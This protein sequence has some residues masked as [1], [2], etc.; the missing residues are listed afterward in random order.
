MNGKYDKRIDQYV[1]EGVELTAVQQGYL[2]A[3]VELL[4]KQDT[5]KTIDVAQ[6]MNK[7]TS[8][9]SSAMRTLNS[10]GI[11]ETNASGGITLCSPG[12]KKPGTKASASKAPAKATSAKLS[13]FN[14]RVSFE[15]P[16][17][18]EMI[19]NEN[20]D[21]TRSCQ[22]VT[23]KYRKDDGNDAYKFMATVSETEIQDPD[24]KPVK[25]EKPL[26]KM[27]RGDPERKFVKI[28]DDPA[29]EF[30]VKAIPLSFLSSQIKLYV[31]VL[32]V[33]TSAK[34]AVI[35]FQ[36][37]TWDEEHPEEHLAQFKQLEQVAKAIR[38]NGNPLKLKR[39]TIDSISKKL[40]PDYDDAASIG[41]I[42][43]NIK[44]DD[45]LVYTD[46]EEQQADLND[47]EEKCRKLNC[48][49]WA[50]QLSDC[51][52]KFIEEIDIPYGVTE[53]GMSAFEGCSMLRRVTIPDT[54]TR[55]E[56]SAFEDCSALEEIEIPDSVTEMQGAIF[57]NCTS[58]RKVT[59]PSG[60]TSIAF[61]MFNGCTELT[62][63]EIPD[64]VTTIEHQAFNACSSLTEIVLPDSI[65]SIGR[66][67][68]DECDSLGVIY[69]PDKEVE[70]E[71]WAI[72][73]NATVIKRPLGKT[74]V[75]GKSKANGNK[76]SKAS[77]P[78]SRFTVVT[79]GDEY[80]SHYGKLKREHEKFTGMGV[81]H[82]SN[83]GKEHEAIP[84]VA[85]MERQGKTDSPVYK[86]LKQIE[87]KDQYN[88]KDTALRMAQVFRV[89]ES[90]YDA[91]HDDEGDISVTMLEKKWE[92]SALR[93]FAWTLADLADREGKS[94]D[95]YGTDDLIEVCG[96]IEQRKWLNYDGGSWFDGLCGHDD[97]HVYYMPQTMIDD[98]S[99]E[100]IYDVFKY[101]PIVS[102]DAFRA[103]L[104]LLKNSM[105]KIHNKLLE[106]RDRSMRL[107]SPEA[108]VLKAWCALVMSAETAF[109]S[110]D[111][112]MVFF[113][114][115]P[116]TPLNSKPI[117]LASKAA[118]QKKAAPKAKKEDPAESASVADKHV[119]TIGPDGIRRVRMG[120][121]P[122]GE[123]I[124]WR[125]LDDSDGET[126]LMV[127]EYAL[128]AMPFCGGFGN[129]T[130][131][132]A[133]STLR[134]WLNDEFLNGAFTG[135]EKNK[136]ITVTHT[137]QKKTKNG[138][139]QAEPTSEK[140]SLL[141]S[142]ELQKYFPSERDRLCKATSYAKSH[143][144]EISGGPDLCNW[145]L[146]SP[147][148]EAMG[149]P[150]WSPRVQTDGSTNGWAYS[151]GEIC[152]RPVIRVKKDFIQ[153]ELIK[154]AGDE[155][156]DKTQQ[157]KK[158][159]KYTLDMLPEGQ[160]DAEAILAELNEMDPEQAEN[161]LSAL[162]AVHKL[163]KELSELTAMFGGNTQEDDSAQR[164]AEER[165]R[166]AQEAQREAEER[167]RKDQEAQ[168]QRERASLEREIASLEHE[169]DS[170]RGLFAGFKRSKIQKQ[171]D[172]LKGRLRR[173]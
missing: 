21:G 164:E 67:A 78:K 70:T 106:N 77:P 48:S 162:I 51:E 46:D 10:K 42:G 2:T 141:D 68:F 58:L 57:E 130:N 129:T 166:K 140:V 104:A 25:G 22:V 151:A 155:A 7:S 128:D 13:K 159:G 107:S 88:L 36:T 38:V 153:S 27:H 87:A 31:K 75:S 117:P 136:I 5:V 120:E 171:I 163:Q 144:A 18:F 62:D 172:E 149:L 35:V 135:A 146:R 165:R 24:G 26:D 16:K 30:Q 90:K 122:A 63:I 71:A 96:F 139:E 84:L 23:G 33:E 147:A 119:L 169:R 138:F 32:C 64:G 158:T 4:E 11:L 34:K 156:R 105:I 54:V 72:P 134:S 45:K 142:T 6:Y 143:G 160:E 81:Q 89:E 41:K 152:V 114:S 8:A 74:K 50:G 15:L 73:D 126:Y 28:S 161:T 47:L 91:R 60:L 82:V 12:K 76:P 168:K 39:I 1:P 115:Y 59:L 116:E 37:A 14:E 49:F 43:L 29:A 118:K 113:H 80:Y 111:G 66:F 109:F 3:V 150:M 17:G 145:W 52:D 123:P 53:I 83:N 101:S 112:P 157:A 148:V 167:R 79:P 61:S 65:E 56:L 98:G 86:K 121:Y 55:I 95:D 132:W 124:V 99:A 127:S 108:S 94:I 97:I 44:V 9:V 103:D 125:I 170:L 93:S 110:E 133:G 154:K 100:G 20:D 137:N 85:L 102:L 19:W 173:L 40:V 69:M 131:E 92:F